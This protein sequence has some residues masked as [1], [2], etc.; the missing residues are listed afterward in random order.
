MEAE[1]QLFIDKLNLTKIK[2][3]HSVK[4][5]GD[6][7]EE[8][9]VSVNGKCKKTGAD[10]IGTNGGL[11]NTYIF[12]ETINPNIIINAGTAGGFNRMGADIGDVYLA[13]DQ[14]VFHDRRIPLPIFDEYGIGRYA[15]F[16]NY[17]L[18]EK[19]QLKKGIISTGNS[20]DYTSSELEFFKN[21][22]VSLKDM[23]AATIAWI[24]EEI[25]KPFVAIKSVTD[26]VDSNIE[27][28]LEFEKNF[29]IAV[30][31][32][33]SKLIDLVEISKN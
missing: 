5:F 1:A 28:A 7:H 11:L 2:Q 32:L 29:E 19:L 33:T 31:N 17:N 10:H 8:I 24:C 23:E 9:F 12:N 18:A 25:E 30:K 3:V 14:A 16:D 13:S 21:N 6:K 27:S 4:I 20:L 26:I 22:N 15:L